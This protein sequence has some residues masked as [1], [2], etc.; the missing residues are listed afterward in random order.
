MTRTRNDFAKA[1]PMTKFPSHPSRRVN[2]FTLIE[3]LVVIAIIAILA[4]LLLPVF[5]TVKI[6]AMK[7]RAKYEMQ[8]VATAIG[9]YDSTYSRM[10]ASSYAAAAAYPDFTFGTYNA[11]FAP[12]VTVMNNSK[13]QPLPKIQNTGSASTYQAPNSEVMAIL[14]DAVTLQDGVTPSI[15]VNHKYNPQQ[16]NFLT[17]KMSGDTKS[18]GVGTDLV[19]RDPWGNPYIFTLDMNGD[20]RCRDAAYSS[21][22]VSG[23]ATGNGLTPD[24]TITQQYPN[25]GGNI[26][27][28]SGMVMI[29]SLGRYGTFDLNGAWNGATNKNAVTSWR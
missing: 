25:V 8:G 6:T 2:G 19:Y 12:G 29:Y 26:Y 5:S 17:P 24:P 18:P 22:A 23:V 20:N 9:Q 14:M 3:L 21:P 7:A 13:N 27:E 1:K 16:N 4:G 28:S 11:G 15:N 10:P